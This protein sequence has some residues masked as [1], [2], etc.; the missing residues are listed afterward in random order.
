M[1]AEELTGLKASP[2]WP[3]IVALTP[4]WLRE[5]EVLDRTEYGVERYARMTAPTLLVLGTATATHHVEATR[6]LESTLPNARVVELRG[7]GHFAHLTA[8]AD[9]AAAIAEFLSDSPR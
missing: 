2:Q 7:Q 4:T 6:A 9:F 5:C 1:S 3:L 8:T